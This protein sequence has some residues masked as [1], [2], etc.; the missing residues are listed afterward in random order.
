MGKR[1]TKA[2]SAAILFLLVTVGTALAN[3][4]DPDVFVV[5]SASLAPNTLFAPEVM[6][7]ASPASL[8]AQKPPAPV[9]AAAV[10]FDPRRA[11]G[12]FIRGERTERAFFTANL[13]TMAALN[14]ADY[15][16][17]S[18]ALKCAGLRE[19]NPL[20]KPFVKSP[21]VFAAVKIG[22]TA[23]SVWGM[24][25]LWKKNKPFAWVLTTASNFMLSYVVANNFR[26]IQRAKR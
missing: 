14:V 19:G 21:A 7:L 6:R 10:N 3:G 1:N 8:S 20:M 4:T 24:N 5:N 26:L 9:Q 11:F 18:R 17:T 23:L 25:S 16:S 15:I 22:T 13:V 12:D 2:S